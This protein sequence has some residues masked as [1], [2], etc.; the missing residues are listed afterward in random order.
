LERRRAQTLEIENLIAGY[1]N[2][3]RLGDH[4]VAIRCAVTAVRILHKFGP[5]HRGL[6]LIEEALGCTEPDARE[7]IE[8]M[9][10]K[11]WSISILG[12]ID[13]AVATNH[14][15]LEQVR[16]LGDI[17]LEA[18]IQSDLAHLT[19][20]INQVSVS[21]S[22]YLQALRL[23]QAVGNRPREA[24]V[25]VNQAM[26]WM[27]QGRLKESQMLLE[28]ALK[29][30]AEVGNVFA[31]AP[32]RS[33]LGLI[34]SSQ[35]RTDE[36]RE[37]LEL[38]ISLLRRMGSRRQEG[39]ALQGLA[40]LQHNVGDLS[41]SLQTHRK[42]LRIH[43]SLG[44]RRQECIVLGNM[45]DLHMSRGEPAQA[46]P[47]FEAAI[48]LGDEVLPAAAGAFRGSLASLVVNR[49]ELETAHELLDRGE[50]ALRGV[51]PSELGK[52]L[53]RRG[54]IALL[55]SS[56]ELAKAA[57]EEVEEIASELGL[58]SQSVLG[59]SIEELREEVGSTTTC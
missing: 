59:R 6:D 5:V 54:R 26:L 9:R 3:V 11:A 15:A 19:G 44:N 29:L 35:G 34:L 55:A 51:N 23:S 17:E 7:Q 12:D 36:A 32:A 52:L 31:E 13:T 27:N 49:G 42:A 33:T 48:E 1:E 45:G 10:E 38:S 8:L 24:L 20:L 41:A 56:P 18:V 4:P 50:A 22:H 14:R 39:S 30:A 37:Q 46:E 2:A 40:T 43:R 58:G 21:D 16:E 28:S 47:L 25:C 57:L 53:C